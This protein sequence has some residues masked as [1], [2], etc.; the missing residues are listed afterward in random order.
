MLGYRAA[1]P[2]DGR[3]PLIS[4]VVRRLPQTEQRNRS[5][6][7]G[8]SP[9]PPSIRVCRSASRSC[10]HLSHETASRRRSAV[11][12]VRGVGRVPA[13]CPHQAS[14]SE[15]VGFIGPAMFALPWCSRRQRWHQ[16]LLRKGGRTQH[17]RTGRA[18]FAS[19]ALPLQ[20]DWDWSD[21]NDGQSSTFGQRPADCLTR[22]D[23]SPPKSEAPARSLVV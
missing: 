2:C 14:G 10:P 5:L 1:V 7:H 15:T 21:E 12:I 8:T 6:F 3:A 16:L 17:H 20:T 18:W 19:S 13:S 4:T 9:R 11:S 22:C 23:C